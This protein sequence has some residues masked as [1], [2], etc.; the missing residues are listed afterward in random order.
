[1]L[2]FVETPA[3]LRRYGGGWR[4]DSVQAMPGVQMLPEHGFPTARLERPGNDDAFKWQ[5]EMFDLYG[6]NGIGI[7]AGAHRNMLTFLT[8]GDG[9]AAVALN[10]LVESLTA[11]IVGPGAE[12]PAAH[13]A[14][15]ATTLWSGRD[16]W[17]SRAMG[18]VFVATIPNLSESNSALAGHTAFA[19]MNPRTSADVHDALIHRS[20]QLADAVYNLLGNPKTTELLARLRQAHT[21]STFTVQDF[22]AAAAATEPS[23][24]PGGIGR[25]TRTWSVGEDTVEHWFGSPPATGPARPVLMSNCR[26]RAGGVSPI[27]CPADQPTMATGSHGEAISRLASTASR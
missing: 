16:R 7:T 25:P 24:E 8:S 19:A 26:P 10:F 1:M 22:V 21:G 17:L 14:M 5:L 27:T 12:A 13:R 6:P 4:L 3:F 20:N 23:L 2:T 9:A 15:T 11:R 18:N